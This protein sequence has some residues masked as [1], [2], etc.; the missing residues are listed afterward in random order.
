MPTKGIDIPAKFWINRN[1][2]NPILCEG[3]NIIE[4]ANTGWDISLV[5][6]VLQMT[7]RV[8]VG[9]AVSSIM[10][11]NVTANKAIV[12]DSLGKIAVDP[13]IDKTELETLDNVNS[14]IQN[15]LNA[16]LEVAKSLIL[17]R[18]TGVIDSVLTR[19]SNLHLDSYNLTEANSKM[20]IGNDCTISRLVM[21]VNTNGT[22][23]DTII[24]LRK[25]GVDTLLAVTIPATQTGVFSDLSNPIP[26][27][28]GDEVNFKIVTGGG[29]FATFGDIESSTMITI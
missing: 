12:S 19:Y 3:I 29:V 26:F 23:S 27:S 1:S 16:K 14:N 2:E 7:S 6:G 5:N 9:G 4:G 22:N 11:S 18:N 20:I 28:T 13:V 10:D 21:K 25:N 8:V 15:Q 17:G 24:T